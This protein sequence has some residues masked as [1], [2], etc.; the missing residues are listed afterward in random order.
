MENKVKEVTLQ[1]KPDPSFTIEGKTVQSVSFTQPD[2]K[3]A[4]FQLKV[5]DFK[6]TGKVVVEASGNGERASFEVP[7]D[8]VNP[9]PLTTVTEDM[10]LEAGSSRKIDLETFGIPGSNNAEV[11]FS[12]LPP[13]NFNGR[14][15][16]LIQ[17]PHGCLEQTT[18]SA[19]PQLFIADIFD[20]NTAKKKEVQ[21]NV[22]SAIKRVGSYQTPNGG[23]AYWPGQNYADDWS[24]SYVGHF[25]LE[26]DKKGYVLPL[27]FKS[28]WVN[29]QQDIARQWRSGTGYSDLA[30]AY[31]LYTLALSGNADIA[32]MNR[33]RESTNLSNEGKFRLAAAYGL[34]GQESV[35]QQIIK[36]ANYDFS[37]GKYEYQTY[38]S[39]DRNRAMAL[40]TFVL[41]NDKV[42]AQEMARNLAQRLSSDQWMS[43]Q[44]TAYCLLALAKF[45]D[46]IGGKGIKASIAVNGGNITI[47]TDKTLANTGLGIKTGTNSI[48]IKNTGENLLY[49]S[50]IKTGI[51]P[52]GEERELQRNLVANV[53]FKGR[54][55]IKL[56]PSSIMQG[57]D[58]VAE[59]SLTNTK[60]ELIKN[61]ALS[62]IFPSGWEIVN[63]RFTDFGDFAENEVTYTDLRDDRANFYFDM[64]KNETK[65]FRVLLNASYLGRYYLPGIQAEA[66]YDYDY[67]VRTKGQ[68]VEVVQ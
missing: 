21:Q 57:T 26:A 55:G 28:S 63:T 43:T 13:M 24:S 11:E 58:F 2:E 62:E 33:L 65:V 14:M 27:G 59:V 12:T 46:M 68:W 29:Y 52:V 9:N 56:D 49:V 18:S 10:V 61:V 31:R 7:I 48:N 51:L 47:N 22:E 16:Y 4:Y 8:V 23:F 37:E 19:F 39:S 34:V 32:S 25:L 5:A 42:K 64:K 60:A 35:A 6:G 45:A 53:V 15:Q 1:I 30:Q 20:I 44:S 54:N 38:G 36:S 67:A 41:L 66:M 17:Y 3:M 50:I 40:E